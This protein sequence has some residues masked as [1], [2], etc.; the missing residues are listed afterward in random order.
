MDQFLSSISESQPDVTVSSEEE[1]VEVLVPE[2]KPYRP[3]QVSS[4]GSHSEPEG[5]T[6][7]PAQKSLPVTSAIT[8]NTHI[9][10]YMKIN[11]TVFP[12][13]QMCSAAT[14]FVPIWT[15]SHGSHLPCGC[16]RSSDGGAPPRAPGGKS[17]E[18]QIKMSTLAFLLGL[19]KG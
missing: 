11:V 13:M 18:G 10:I 3:F 5:E 9:N 2:G 17:L 14:S 1:S 19:T 4:L 16:T 8:I 15:L 6:Q 7:N 12:G